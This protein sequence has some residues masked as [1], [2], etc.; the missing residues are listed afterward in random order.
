MHVDGGSNVMIVA[1]TSLLHNAM[2]TTNEV[3]NTRGGT[4]KTT[5]AGDMHMLLESVDKQVLI[6]M[7]QACF[8][9]SNNHNTFGLSKFL[10]HGCKRV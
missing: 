9:P 10:I 7:K 6:K 4:A 5:H 2:Q 8:M 3:G 1:S